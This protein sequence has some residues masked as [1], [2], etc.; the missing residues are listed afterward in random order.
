M[1]EEKKKQ[2]L[3]QKKYKLQNT[4]KITRYHEKWWE[5]KINSEAKKAKI[6]LD[7]QTKNDYINRWVF[8]D[9]SKALTKKNFPDEKV[10]NWAKTMDKVNFL[11]FA[12]QIV[13]PFEN[14]FLELGAKVL[15][16]VDNLISASP[17]AAVI[18]SDFLNY[19]FV[20]FF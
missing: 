8:G 5:N 3:L 18:T 15:T 7:T 6:K 13:A 2:K 16:N 11:K 17:E 19:K 12:Q 4:D 10:L 1:K 20:I 9:K 14:L